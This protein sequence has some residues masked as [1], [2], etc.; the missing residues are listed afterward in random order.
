M[1]LKSPARN[2]DLKAVRIHISGSVW[3]LNMLTEMDLSCAIEEELRR[4]NEKSAAKDDWWSSIENIFR[5]SSEDDGQENQPSSD[6]SANLEAIVRL[7]LKKPHLPKLDPLAQNIVIAAAFWPGFSSDLSRW[8][9]TIDGEGEMRQN[10]LISTPENRDAEPYT[11]ILNIGADEAARLVQLAD[12]LNFATFRPAIESITT[13]VGSARL[14]FRL[15]GE[16][17]TYVDDGGGELSEEYQKSFRQL[18][19]EVRQ[20][21]PFPKR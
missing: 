8:D 20:H 17:V 21:A 9:L 4:K 2:D 3:N 18:W 14:S 10:I 16:I 6:I 13:D 1:S 15:G 19:K 12:D 11:E 5:L 7:V